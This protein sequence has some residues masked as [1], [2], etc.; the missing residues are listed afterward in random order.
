M[1]KKELDDLRLFR[2][3]SELTV[4]LLKQLKDFKSKEEPDFRKLT[5]IDLINVMANIIETKTK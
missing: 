1:S 3:K 5:T 4:V 2:V